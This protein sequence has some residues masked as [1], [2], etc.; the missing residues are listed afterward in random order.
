MKDQEIGGRTGAAPTEPDSAGRAPEELDGGPRA[1]SSRAR[2]DE[3]LPPG[4]VV[5][6]FIV[7]RALGMGGAG[8][9][10]AAHDPELDRTIALK[11]LLRE[12]ADR[13][14]ARARFLREAQALARL[15]HPNVISV[16][17]VGTARGYPFIAMEYIQGQTFADWAASS[18]ASWSEIVS[19]LVKAG[20]GLAAAHAAG[21]IHRDFKPTNLLVSV[22]GRVVVTDFGLAQAV[23]NADADAAPQGD[24]AG[25]SSALAESI[26]R[27][28]SVLG[29]PAYM[30]PEQQRGEP[31]D[32]RAD[33][34]SFCVSLYE[35]VFREHPFLRTSQDA[36]GRE[37]TAPR[38]SDARGVPLWLQRTMQRG[39]SAKPEDRYPN[40]DG[41]LSA[42][43]RGPARRRRLRQ[44]ALA[45][46]AV[47]VAVG[48]LALGV[49]AITEPRAES[50]TG[51][52]EQVTGIWNLAVAAGVRTAFA[53][54]ARPHAGMT[55]DRV[56]ER[57]DGYTSQWAAM[58]RAACV[59]N[60]RGEQSPDLLDRRMACLGRRLAQVGTL[61]DQFVHRAD[62]DLVDRAV[63]AV[64]HLEPLAS[65][66]D[67]AALLS[68]A[69]PPADPVR[70]ARAIELEHQ[71][72]RAD[73]ELVVGRAQAAMDSARAVV[74]AER[75]V[76]YASLAARAGRV[77]GRSL[78]N[79]GRPAEARAALIDARRRAESAG[80]TRLALHLLSDLVFVIGVREQHFAEADLLG[81]LAEA[82]LDRPDLRDDREARAWL[83]LALGHLATKEGHGD[84]AIELDRELVAIRRQ[85][86]P[87]S[88]E[89]VA[90]AEEELGIALTNAGRHDEAR[91]HYVESLATR[92][93]LYG[94][95]HPQTANVHLNLGTSYQEQGNEA[96][97]RRHYLAALDFF[98]R[99]PEYQGHPAL[100][101][102]LGN[103]ERTAG[104]L[105]LARGYHEAALAMRLRQFGPEHPDVAMSLQNLG[106]LQNDLGDP[107]EALA[108]HRRALAIKEK[109]L[110][111]KH[112]SYA[113]ALASVGEDLRQLGRAAESLTYQEQSLE[114]LRATGK[115]HPVIGVV[116]AHQGFALLDLGRRREAIAVLE[117]ALPKIPASSPERARAAFALARALEPLRPRSQRVRA[118]ADEALATFTAVHDH[119]DRDQVTAYLARAGQ[120]P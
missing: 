82:A 60:A 48:G 27:T 90:R 55:A 64:A 32:A 65:C 9:V 68:I 36:P 89:D 38:P 4:T 28:G 24:H 71:T 18:R 113:T 33:Q 88:P 87:S 74:A 106:N 91:Q 17:D 31:A 50:C 96:E 95:D 61:L 78:E 51:A 102:N 25:R 70:R 119:R 114:I 49:G 108:L 26:T 40:M 99:V 10:Y 112:R 72:D 101:N 86:T 81:Q 11:L 53:T 79:L 14:D 30:A 103:L 77:L 120:A 37:G 2:S 118:L 3:I 104:H 110:G 46:V 22:D 116:L 54:T 57:L 93:R 47:A 115:D 59:A 98:Q 6:R 35:A 42:L 66:A 5:D 97:A 19:V 21:L 20:R 109:T 56:A 52:R 23:T 76:D 117:G 63:D 83:L 8:V 85:T 29:T 69:P 105:E 58:H 7:H 75:A 41:L 39:L 15:S 111:T 43:N 34:F 92:R 16:Y 1:S 94:E 62:G 67:A 100:L 84:R 45:A 13:A 12:L 73:L 44:L 80:D 107:A